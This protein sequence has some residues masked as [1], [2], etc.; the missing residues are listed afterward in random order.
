MRRGSVISRVPSALPG[1][2]WPTVAIAL[3]NTIVTPGVARS[4]PSS[5]ARQRRRSVAARRND[6]HRRRS[7]FV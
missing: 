2:P 1:P 4:S 3:L 5:D 7:L 6:R